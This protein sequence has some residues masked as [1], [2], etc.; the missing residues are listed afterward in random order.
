MARKR[1]KYGEWRETDLREGEPH[2]GSLPWTDEDRNFWQ[3]LPRCPY[4]GS[5]PLMTKKAFASQ[6]R[7]Q[8]RCVHLVLHQCPNPA[9]TGWLN[10]PQQAARVWRMNVLLAGGK[11]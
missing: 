4:C 6:N 8:I 7:Y 2:T 9:G 5:L 11:L 3:H 10:N 1:D